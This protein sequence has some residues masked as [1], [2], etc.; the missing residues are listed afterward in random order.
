MER[1]LER[2]VDST[3]ELAGTGGPSATRAGRV[4]R[5][6][7][8]F[9]AA[10][11]DAHSVDDLCRGGSVGVAPSTFRR[12]CRAE[13][14]RPSRVLDLARLLRA[15]ILAREHGTPLLEWMEID[16]RTFAVLLQRAAVRELFDGRLP[17]AEEFIDNQQ[18]VS[19]G[20]LLKAV[21]RIL[22]APL[23]E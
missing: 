2:N 6:L 21:Q 23:A 17:T 10:T 14:V 4:G 3:R 12:W 19:N 22:H 13:R 8:G 1:T 5:L 20:V 16:P 7:V 11:V 15:L 18:L 9:L